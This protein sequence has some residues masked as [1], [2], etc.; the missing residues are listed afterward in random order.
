MIHGN[1]AT[2]LSNETIYI[3]FRFTSWNYKPYQNNKVDDY[4]YYKILANYIVIMYARYHIARIV[5]KPCIWRFT[6]KMLL[7]R[8]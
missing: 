4:N 2:E 7:T 5:G 1:M 3:L 8:F 6:L